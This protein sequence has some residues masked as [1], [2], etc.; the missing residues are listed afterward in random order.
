MPSTPAPRQTA[1]RGSAVRSGYG[2]YC[3]CA[4]VHCVEIALHPLFEAWLTSLTDGS[5]AG[6]TDWWEVAAEITALL[7]ALERHGRNLGDPECH[8]VV[9]EGH[10]ERQRTTATASRGHGGPG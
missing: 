9:Q 8:E 7:A 1:D 2:L 4:K 6:G 3:I 5:L 10:N